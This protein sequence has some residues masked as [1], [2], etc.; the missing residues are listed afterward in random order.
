MC[1]Y[2]TYNILWNIERIFVPY[3]LSVCVCVLSTLDS[4]SWP[5]ASLFLLLQEFP[6]RLW[7]RQVWRDG[8]QV[9][10]CKSKLRNESIPVK[11][12]CSYLNR[13][14]LNRTILS[15]QEK[16]KVNSENKY[17]HNFF[18]LYCTCERP[19]PDPE[20]KVNPDTPQ[21]LSAAFIRIINIEISTTFCCL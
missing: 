15:L 2:I 14:I 7:K 17:S 12:T 10:L 8:M 18:G 21:M 11:I 1:C 9:I 3:R 16:E 13:L 5:L 19:Y 20:D 6:L 4:V